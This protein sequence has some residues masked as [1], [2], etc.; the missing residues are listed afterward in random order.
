VLRGGDR[1]ERVVEI[2]SDDVLVEAFREMPRH[3]T[4]GYRL[5]DRKNARTPELLPVR[6]SCWTEQSFRHLRRDFVP[7]AQPAALCP[8][9]STDHLVSLDDES[10]ARCTRCGAEMRVWLVPSAR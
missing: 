10:G 1:G 4:R 5:G 8:S 2:A 7:D 6:C 3:G 9:C